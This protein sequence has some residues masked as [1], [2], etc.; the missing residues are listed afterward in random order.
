MIPIKS[1]DEWKM[2]RHAGRIVA[3][4]LEELQ[5]LIEP[6]RTTLELDRKAQ[7]FIREHQAVPAFLGYHGFPATLCT[8]LNE[9]VVHGIPSL[10]QLNAGD[11]ISIDVGVKYQGWYADGAWT[12]PVGE[13]DAATQKLLATTQES[14]FKG[15]AAAREKNHLSDI[16]HAVQTHVEA[17]GF[18]VVRDFVG[19]GIGR[20]LH[21]E[22]QVPNHGEPGEG[23]VL[24]SG[25]VLA[26]EPMVNAG[27]FAVKTLEDG[28]TVVSQDGSR[29][30][31]F[32]HT[33]V[34]TPHG[35]EVLT[36]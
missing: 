21:E 4:V 7:S 14:L 32:E 36:Q 2:I 20:D 31:H 10:V 11:I 12:Y 33:V 19:H 26:I 34:I 9:Q 28:W 29:S 35:A 5:P 8:S 18:S 15:I 23:V 6:G 3:Q 25:M 1:P 17:A 22:P 13:V 16:G 30:A 27:G 24:K